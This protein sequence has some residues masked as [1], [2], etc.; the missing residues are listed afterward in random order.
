MPLTRPAS[1]DEILRLI[2][3]PTTKR[4]LMSPKYMVLLTGFAWEALVDG[5]AVLHAE[6]RVE[7]AGKPGAILLSL[8]VAEAE[9]QGLKLDHSGIRWQDPGKPKRKVVRVRTRKLPDGR[10]IVVES[11]LG[12]EEKRERN[13]RAAPD[14]DILTLLSLERATAKIIVGLSPIWP[15]RLDTDGCPG[16][17]RRRQQL[18]RWKTEKRRVLKLGKGTVPDPPELTYCIRCDW[19]SRTGDTTARR[20]R[21][22]PKPGENNG[23]KGGL[24]ATA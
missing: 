2:S 3:P 9:A 10:K 12:D 13:E 19:D 18:A 1:P 21:E 4:A 6:N 20:R 14:P 23:L 22:R 5:L 16:C 7:I 24:G 11:D 17:R 8:S 15:V